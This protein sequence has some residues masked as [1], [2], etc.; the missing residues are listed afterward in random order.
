[1]II[2][3]GRCFPAR[4]GEPSSSHPASLAHLVALGPLLR[5]EVGRAPDVLELLDDPERVHDPRESAHKWLYL[6]VKAAYDQR[7]RLSDPLGVV[8]EIYADFGPR[9]E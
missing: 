2:R 5:D 8:E 4:R 7:E 3:P 1:L 6:Q 9:T